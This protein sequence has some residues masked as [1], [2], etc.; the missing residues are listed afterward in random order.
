M[1]RKQRNENNGL[2]DW[3]TYEPE[4]AHYFQHE[5]GARS[6][7]LEP[8]G[9]PTED[10]PRPPRFALGADYWIMMTVAERLAVADRVMPFQRPPNAIEW[11][12][13]SDGKEYPVQVPGLPG[14]PSCSSVLSAAYG[15]LACKYDDS[16]PDGAMWLLRAKDAYMRAADRV[17]ARR[18]PS[19]MQRLMAKLDLIIGAE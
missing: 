9:A 4:V 6:A 7:N 8:Q 14:Q 11:R 5:P 16:A 19:P 13:S 18:R 15:G 17:Q 12:A 10:G 3:A 1:A 2:S